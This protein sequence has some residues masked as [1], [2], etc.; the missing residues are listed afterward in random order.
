MGASLELAATLLPH[1]N[2]TGRCKTG[3]GGRQGLFCNLSSGGRREEK[4]KQSSGAGA[5]AAFSATSA[6]AASLSLS[7]SLLLACLLAVKEGALKFEKWDLSFI[8]KLSLMR[9]A[10]Q[11]T[12]CGCWPSGVDQ[13]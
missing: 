1:N 5:F 10:V 11:S 7:L 6:T 12:L 2:T 8:M 13:G 3:V 4:R 9:T